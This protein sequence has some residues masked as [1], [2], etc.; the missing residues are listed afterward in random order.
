MSQIYKEEEEEKKTDECVQPEKGMISNVEE[1]C[2][3]LCSID[4][5]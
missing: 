2:E 3:S 1:W 4:I 5:A